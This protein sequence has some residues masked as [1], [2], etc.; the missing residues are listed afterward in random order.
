MNQHSARTATKVDP[1]AFRQSMRHVPTPVAI[2]ATTS[3]AG[4]PIGLTVGSFAS[5][6]LDPALVTFFVD[7]QS[8]TWPLMED[9]GTFTVNILGHGKGER[10]RSF[11]SR[12]VD[13][14]S[15]VDWTASTDGDPVLSEASLVL[16]CSKHPTRVLGDH[17]Q[18]VGEVSKLHV[19]HED[20][21]LVYHQGT[22]LNLDH[23]ASV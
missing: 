17:L 12:G 13:R 21:P 18:V 6:S 15:G 1:A 2:V 10:C 9:S 14:F 22:F 16:E 4:Q 3:A 23:L 20:L 19:L 7:K 8:T 11:S 5:V